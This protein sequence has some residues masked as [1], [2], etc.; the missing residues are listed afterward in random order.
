V[1]NLVDS[2]QETWGNGPTVQLHEKSFDLHCELATK[3]NIQFYRKG[4]N[5]VSVDGSIKRE[6]TGKNCSWLDKKCSVSPL[7]N[8]GAQVTPEELTKRF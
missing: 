4:I 6:D 1:A 3:L 5:V 8:N 2:L 7:S